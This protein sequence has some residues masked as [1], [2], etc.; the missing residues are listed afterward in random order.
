MRKTASTRSAGGANDARCGL[1]RYVPRAVARQAKLIIRHE[2][3]CI[4]NGI[5]R[6]VRQYPHVPGVDFAGRVIDSAK[7]SDQFLWDLRRTVADMIAENYVGGLR[8][9]AHDADGVREVV[10]AGQHAAQCAPG[11]YPV[12]DFSALGPAIGPAFPNTV[13]GK[14][15][16]Q[17]EGLFDLVMKTIDPL[18]IE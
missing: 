5:G 9:V 6:L 18:L 10:S 13:G 16:V 8:D 11:E 2:P 14:V 3:G 4:L 15:V 17:H 7:K 12:A 1:V